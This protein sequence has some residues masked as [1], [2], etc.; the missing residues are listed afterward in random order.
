MQKSAIGAGRLAHVGWEHNPFVGSKKLSAEKSVSGH[1]S[2]SPNK[3]KCIKGSHQSSPEEA[4]EESFEEDPVV[5]YM[6]SAQR[7]PSK[8]MTRR[9]ISKGNRMMAKKASTT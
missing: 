2:E 4:S 5:L 7:R 3:G 9:N 1:Q 8:A 6:L